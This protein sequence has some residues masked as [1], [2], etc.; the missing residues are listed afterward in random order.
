MKQ[1]Q[2]FT[3]DKLTEC[4]ERTDTGDKYDTVLKAV[5]KEDLK[6]VLRRNKWNFTCKAFLKKPDLQVYKLVLKDDPSEEIQGLISLQ[7]MGGFV[8]LHH[9]ENAPHNVGKTKVYQGVCGN[10]VAFGC[11][12][13]IELGFDG[14]VGF[15]AKT[16]LIKHYEN[17]LNAVVNQ[18]AALMALGKKWETYCERHYH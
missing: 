11:K 15:K 17:T 18:G 16:N 1:E 12:T 8:E 14:Y 6:N 7:P 13:S 4:I 9:I 5:V 10:L 2:N 3:I